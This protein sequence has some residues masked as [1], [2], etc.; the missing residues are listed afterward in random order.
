MSYYDREWEPYV[1][2]AQRKANGKREA[3]KRLKKG[4]N[5]Q[6]VEIAGRTIVKTFWGQAWCDHFESYRDFANRLPR[7]RTYARNGS[8]ADLRITTGRIT[9]MV[10]GSDLYQVEIQIGPLKAAKWKA[11]RK[12]C[13]T[14]VH[15]LIDLMRGKLSDD[16]IARLTD[17]KEGM[18]PIGNEMS[19]SCDC[20]DYSRLCKHLAAVMYGVGNRL[21][22]SPELLFVLRGV[23][24]SELIAEALG[25][26]QASSAMG[27]DSQSDLDGE[28]LGAIFGIEMAEV[29][30]KRKSVRKAPVKK[31][32]AKKKEP[33]K[34]NIVKKK[35]AK[36]KPGKKQPTK[37]KPSS[38]KKPAKKSAAKKSRKSKD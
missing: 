17:A 14:S 12:G 24:Q 15:S 7:G 23:D 29:P 36:K 19:L 1:P 26:D 18:F 6:P 2:V 8:I 9:G 16:V 13:G 22:A 5:L 32:L 34:K 4:E 30:T 11:I 27:L 33:K 25:S 35:A 37:R 3:K 31:K 21:D 28:D 38:K 10:C 20:P